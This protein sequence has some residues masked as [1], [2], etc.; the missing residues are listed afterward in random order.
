MSVN[1][2]GHL[3]RAMPHPALHIVDV[4]SLVDLHRTVSVAQVVKPN[5][6]DFGLPDSIWKMHAGIL[7]LLFS[8]PL[9]LFAGVLGLG[10]RLPPANVVRIRGGRQVVATDRRD[11]EEE[12]ASGIDYS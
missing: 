9:C 2:D 12:R 1:V 4:L 7:Q 6:A 8:F 10:F 11:K 3:D 5:G